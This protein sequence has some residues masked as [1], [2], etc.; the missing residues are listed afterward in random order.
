MTQ[1]T[2][3][4]DNMCNDRLVSTQSLSPFVR[5]AGSSA[6]A[7]KT[8]ELFTARSSAKVSVPSTLSM[9]ILNVDLLKTE[10]QHNVRKAAGQTPFATFASAGNARCRPCQGRVQSVPALKLPRQLRHKHNMFGMLYAE[11]NVP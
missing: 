2:L 9:H 1:E 7:A 10:K 4:A 8:A 5:L 3:L 11:A 6:I